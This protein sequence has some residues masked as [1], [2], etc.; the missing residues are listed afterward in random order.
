MRVDAI[1]GRWNPQSRANR[2]RAVS[3]ADG[4]ASLLGVRKERIPF[5]RTTQRKD[6]RVI[7]RP[8]HLSLLTFGVPSRKILISQK[9]R[10]GE[11]GCS[12]FG[13]RSMFVKRVTVG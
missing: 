8:G 5:T 1:C 11:L 10:P 12:P 9:L 3:L 4:R 13:Y 2:K 7:D 6:F